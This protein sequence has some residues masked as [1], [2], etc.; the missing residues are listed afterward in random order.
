MTKMGLI[1]LGAIG[2][3]VA[4]HVARNHTTWLWNR[5]AEKAESLARVTGATVAIDPTALVG[6]VEIVFTCLPTTT[7]VFEVVRD[8][9]TWRKGQFYVS[10]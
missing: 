3:P 8:V 1:G 2:Y 7:E 9:D 10:S 5:T 4:G 6:C